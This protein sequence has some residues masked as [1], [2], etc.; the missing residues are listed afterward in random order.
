VLRGTSPSRPK[1]AGADP[2]RSFATFGEPE[3]LQQQS[4]RNRETVIDGGIAHVG[5]RNARSLLG[6]GDGDFGRRA[7]SR[8]ARPVTLLMGMG[9]G[10][11]AD[12]NPGITG[13]LAADHEGGAAIGD[14]AAIQQFSAAAPPVSTAITSATVIGSWNCAPGWVSACIAHQ[15]REFGKVLLRHVI[16]MHIARGDEAVMGG[17]R[18]PQRPPRNRDGPTCARA[19]IEASRGSAR[20]GG[21]RRRPPARAW[22]HPA[23]AR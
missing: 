20:S 22:R 13:R 3:I 19:T 23:S 8:P 5:D 21:S 10:A 12:A 7:R 18:R 4:Q 16:V 1:I 6:L 2:C 17:N 11:A 9:L 15:H 14:R